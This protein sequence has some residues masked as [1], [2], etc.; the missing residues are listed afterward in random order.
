MRGEEPKHCEEAARRLIE[1]GF[2]DWECADLAG[3]HML[4]RLAGDTISITADGSF[5]AFNAI[6]ARTLRDLGIAAAVA[7]AETEDEQI[8][9]AAP[10]VSKWLIV[11]VRWRRPL[12]ISETR[13]VVPWEPSDATHMELA[14]RRGWRCTVDAFDGRWLTR[15]TKPI[16]RSASLAAFR[17][18]GYTMFRYDFTDTAQSLS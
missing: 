16:D 14:D 11:P 18:A 8:L 6:A 4:R 10:Y 13:P 1:A 7:P 17:E 9:E 3:L 2:R 5:Y 12:F 15:D